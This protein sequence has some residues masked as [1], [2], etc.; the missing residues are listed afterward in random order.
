MPRCLQPKKDVASDE[1]RRGD[2]SGQRSVDIRMGQP[3]SRR[4]ITCKAGGESV[5]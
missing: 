3:N 4:A 2:A 5:K 1:T